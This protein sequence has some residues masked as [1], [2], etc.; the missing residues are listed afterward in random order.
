[1]VKPN[2]ISETPVRTQAICVRS[3]AMR[4]RSHPKWLSEVVR[5]SKRP[6]PRL[7]A[8]LMPF[9]PTPEKAEKRYSVVVAAICQ[10]LASSN[11]FLYRSQLLVL[12]DEFLDIDSSLDWVQ[13]LHTA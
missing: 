6:E 1:M 8:S 12:F 7:G 9:R 2:A 4:V 5:T 10:Y 11:S 13:Q 3:S